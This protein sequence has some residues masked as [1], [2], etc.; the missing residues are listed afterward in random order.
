MKIELTDELKKMVID[1]SKNRAKIM[2]GSKLKYLTDSTN[3]NIE[4]L[5]EKFKL[6]PEAFNFSLKDL[7]RMYTK[8]VEDFIKLYNAEDDTERTK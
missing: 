7:A 4:V 2:M 1:L 8:G 5:M 6:T 3:E